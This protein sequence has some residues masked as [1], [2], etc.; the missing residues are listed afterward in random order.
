MNEVNKT[1]YI[2]LYGKSFVSRKGI[3]LHDSKAEEIWA[4]EGFELK[5]RS[6]SKWLAYNMAMRARVFDDW[7]DQELLKNPDAIVLHIGCGLDG[8][9]LRV[10][11]PY[12]C[13]YDCDFPDV[14]GVRRQ[15]Y[16]ESS[17]Y[18]M[19]ELD[20]TDTEKINE[21]PEGNTV[22][23]VLEGISM[24]LTN[25][26]LKALITAL[27]QKYLYVHVL[28]D[29]YTE[30]G[31]RASERKNPINDVGVTKV[32]GLDDIDGLLEGTGVMKI[33]EHSFTPKNLID[34]LKPSERCFFKLLFTGKTYGRIYRLFELKSI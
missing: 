7:T 9:C 18:H 1:L 3:I 6:R 21:L 19:M 10:K 20:A 14:L 8:R 15:Y 16:Q 12:K 27:R 25:D 33:C 5:G 30:Y 22:I 23:V 13:W 2:P 4:K 34:E 11:N 32:Y 28:L 31:A 17:F 24:Y 29:V 26:Q